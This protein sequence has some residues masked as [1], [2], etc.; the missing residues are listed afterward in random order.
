[1]YHHEEKNFVE[2]AAFLKVGPRTF[3]IEQYVD[4]YNVETAKTENCI[5]KECLLRFSVDTIIKRVILFPHFRL[6]KD[7]LVLNQEV[8]DI[9]RVDKQEDDSNK[10]A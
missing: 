3:C 6:L 4:E 2:I 1:M 5:V 9:E 7:S 8:H 10:I